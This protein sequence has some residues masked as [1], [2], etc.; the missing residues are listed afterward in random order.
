MNGMRHKLNLRTQK[1]SWKRF[2]LI[3]TDS[4]HFIR[5]STVGVQR[6]FFNEAIWENVRKASVLLN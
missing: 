2:P 5:K 1:D 6:R 3:R 4:I